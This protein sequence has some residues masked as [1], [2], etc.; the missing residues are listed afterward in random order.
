V[1]HR[2]GRALR[3]R[4]GRA[5]RSPKAGQVVLAWTRETAEL[6]DPHL[7]RID[8]GEWHKTRP[9]REGL[10]VMW[11]RHGT[12]A[13]VEK[14]KAHAAKEQSAADHDPLYAT[15][16]GYRVFVYPLSEKDPLGRARREVLR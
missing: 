10:A 12:E 11:A 1:K 8:L 5:G 7:T 6:V 4:Y 9:V 16:T 2:R 3:R 14:A 15:G 13:D